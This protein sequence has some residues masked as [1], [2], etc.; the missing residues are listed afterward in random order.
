MRI[1]VLGGGGVGGYFGAQLAKA[2]HEVFFVARGAHLQAMQQHGLRVDSP[3][4]PVHL[5]PVHTGSDPGVMRDPDIVLFCPKLWDV[6]AAAAQLAPGLGPD[7]LVIPFQNGVESHGWLG[8]VLGPQRVALGVA[9]IASTIGAPGVIS[10]TGSFARMRVGLLPALAADV[11]ISARLDAFVAAGVAAGIDIVRVP[12]ALR[13]LWE[14]FVFLAAMSGLTS[15]VRLPIGP[16][17]SDPDQRAT[18]E[19]SMRE[20]AALAAAHGVVFEPDFIERQM[21][22]VDGL[23]AD[24][25]SSMLHDLLAGRRLE[26][27]WLCG[28]VARMSAE[29]GLPSPV[30]RTLFAALKPFVDGKPA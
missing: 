27:P 30:N 19:A 26:A 18:L 21:G 3:L 22:F 8:D 29:R 7:T 14:K 17:R 12:D 20:T 5:Q 11:R 23:H 25:R 2:G 28:G 16:I 24:M 13:T 4:S 6:K 15:L 10:H 9:Q 1:L